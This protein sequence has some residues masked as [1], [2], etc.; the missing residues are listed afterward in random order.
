MGACGRGSRAGPLASR[1]PRV[2][3]V[4]ALALACAGDAGGR[5]AAGSL[6]GN[7]DALAVLPHPEVKLNRQ[8][9]LPDKEG[10][11]AKLA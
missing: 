3:A 8:V 7:A 9:R 4:L 6:K 2:A 1:T 5:D 11:I 10:R